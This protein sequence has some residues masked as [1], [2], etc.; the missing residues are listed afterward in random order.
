M[1]VRRYP[2]PKYDIHDRRN[3]KWNRY[4]SYWRGRYNP[5][6]VPA[7]RVAWRRHLLRPARVVPSPQKLKRILHDE[8]IWRV[9]RRQHEAAKR[10][11][12]QILHERHI[13]NLIQGQRRFGFI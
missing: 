7:A 12:R 11:R 8:L 5:V 2:R 4:H 1:Y 9:R 6:H 10:R 13:R 3:Y